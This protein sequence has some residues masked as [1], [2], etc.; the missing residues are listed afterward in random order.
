VK[1][2]KAL[3]IA[4]NI[5]KRPELVRQPSTPRSLK[6]TR[7]V[8]WMGKDMKLIAVVGRAGVYEAMAL[9][10]FAG[11]AVLLSMRSCRSSQRRSPT[12]FLNAA[13]RSGREPPMV[14]PGY[15]GRTRLSAP[16]P[17]HNPSRPAPY[18]GASFCR[19]HRSGSALVVP[20]VTHYLLSVTTA[21]PFF[22]FV[23]ALVHP[24]PRCLILLAALLLT[25]ST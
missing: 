17:V 25:R 21:S 23:L 7:T 13:M 16:S 11:M 18:S 24:R 3:L 5:A 22:G 10:L 14:G 6:Q 20:L 19:P 1:R 15:R 8:V 4:P 12:L 2:Q 9:A